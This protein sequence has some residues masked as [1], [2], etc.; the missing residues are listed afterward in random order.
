MNYNKKLYT[1]FMESVCADFN[2]MDAL[3]A[4]KDGFAALCESED[5]DSNG[6]LKRFKGNV[7]RVS[8][9]QAYLSIPLEDFTAEEG[10]RMLDESGWSAWEFGKGTAEDAVKEFKSR[11][12]EDRCDKVLVDR[13]DKYIIVDSYRDL[14]DG[15]YHYHIYGIK[16][17]NKTDEPMGDDYAWGLSPETRSHI[18]EERRD[19]KKKLDDANSWG[20]KQRDRAVESEA[21][22]A[23]VKRF[24]KRK[25]LLDDFLNSTTDRSVWMSPDDDDDVI[26]RR[27]P[28][29]SHFSSGLD[30]IPI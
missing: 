19:S 16:I 1:A 23:E 26:V 6:A 21:R 18:R 22:L 5:F 24:L 2:C 17:E 15:D 7:V 20:A 13:P 9:S 12:G 29:H 25:G 10:E 8:Q 27:H 11:K 30:S 14:G 3:P 28:M 4:L